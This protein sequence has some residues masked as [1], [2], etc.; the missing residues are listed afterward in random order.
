MSFFLLDSRHATGSG[1]VFLRTDM[2]WFLG[3]D[4][5]T[6]DRPRQ[7]PSTVQLNGP[8][9]ALRPRAASES[10]ERQGGHRPTAQT[11]GGRCLRVAAA[12]RPR[13]AAELSS[14]LRR[15]HHR[16][17][18]P[19]GRDLAPTAGPSST[20]CSFGSEQPESKRWTDSTKPASC[21]C[22]SPTRSARFPTPRRNHQLRARRLPEG[23]LLRPRR[24]GRCRSSGPQ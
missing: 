1:T 13:G 21:R 18:T 5:L 4:F 11:S 3:N 2:T 23:Q 24:Q 10:K 9:Q 15:V 12:G 7:H 6:E 22:Q 14:S 8:A 17:T 16:D 19:H 20:W